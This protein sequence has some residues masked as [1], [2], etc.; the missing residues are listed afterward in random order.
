MQIEGLSVRDNHSFVSVS[1]D[2]TIKLGNALGS[3]LNE[4]DVLVLTGDLGAG[5]TQLT[6]GIASAMGVTT[7]IT[8]PTFTIQMVHEGLD[9]PL[10]HFD[11]YRLDDPS[12][13]GDCG[14][15]D[16]LG[17]EGVC[18][19]EWGEQFIDEIGDNRLDVILSRLETQQGEGVEPARC[20]QLVSH[21]ARSQEIIDEL[22]KQ[23]V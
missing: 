1:T 22:L 15:W 17:Y 7:P 6:K 19:I 10:F 3:I 23:L 4:G 11:L 2:A 20:I 13:L 12:Q 14:L 18:V 8:S 16:V 21:D 9:M 5:K